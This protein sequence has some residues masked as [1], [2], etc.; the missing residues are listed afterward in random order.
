[1]QFANTEI[2]K[3]IKPTDSV[4]I[5][6]LDSGAVKR[7]ITYGSEPR[8]DEAIILWFV[9][10]QILA[11]SKH[12]QNPGGFAKTLRT[13]KIQYFELWAQEGRKFQG[14]ELG[15]CQTSAKIR[16][17]RFSSQHFSLRRFN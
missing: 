15:F 12:G 6:V 17:K 2:E 8:Q 1:M 16:D 5:Y 10:R 11:K 9:Q 4:R 7:T 14:L 3:L 13:L